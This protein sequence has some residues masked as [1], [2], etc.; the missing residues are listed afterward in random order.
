[1]SLATEATDSDARI[2]GVRS[3]STSTSAIDELV[4]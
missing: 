3:T 1:L 2:I 4:P